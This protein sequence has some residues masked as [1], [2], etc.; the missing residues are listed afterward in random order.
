MPLLIEDITESQRQDQ[1]FAFHFLP[2]AQ[3]RSFGSKEV[4]PLLDKW[5]FGPDMAMCTFRV[6]QQVQPD[7]MQVMLE[8]FFRDREVLG[9]LQ[10]LTGLRVFSPERLHVNW[11]RMGTK[12][13]SM[14]F[15]N[16]FQDCGAIGKSGHIRG[17]LD[18]D[19]E[20]VLLHNLIQE[21]IL[22]EESELYDTFSEQDRKEFL[23]RILSHL[24]F[25]GASNQWEDHVEEYF[26]VTKEVY[27]DLLSVRRNDTG[28]VEV[29]STVASIRSLG[30]G[31]RIFPKDSPLNFCYVILDPLMRHLRVWYFG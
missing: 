13:T 8:A 25:G 15:F 9:V 6:E 31:G 3:F 17:R 11:E 23:F 4:Q 20:G 2:D 27:K 10:Q 26:K 19:C 18:E 16:K 30:E 22:M 1:A 7:E 12:V 21:V 29:M 24:V 28:D 14:S 5:G